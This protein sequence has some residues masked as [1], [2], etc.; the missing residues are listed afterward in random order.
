[1]E[2]IE[3]L[4]LVADE[5]ILMEVVDGR[6]RA[7]VPRADVVHL[8]ICRTTAAERPLAQTILGIVLLS[9]LY[10]PITSIIDWS[11]YGG[12]LYD[13]TVLICI[14]PILLGTWLLFT[15]LRRSVVMRAHTKSGTRKLLIGRRVDHP[16]L[17]AF[18]HRLSTAYNI[19]I[20]NMVDVPSSE[21]G[22]PAR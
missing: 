22:Q 21:G 6:L 10:V 7:H 15:A 2:R 19:P 5:S 17:H 14:L 9:A 3:Y 13:V 18:T 11:Q 12:A 16:E 20:R 8:E 4:N 1:M